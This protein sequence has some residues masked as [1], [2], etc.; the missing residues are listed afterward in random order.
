M[1]NEFSKIYFMT[2]YQ[3]TLK[4]SEASTQR[5]RIVIYRFFIG[6]KS[7]LM[8]ARYLRYDLRIADKEFVTFLSLWECCPEILKL[9]A[10]WNFRCYFRLHSR[11][12]SSSI[13]LSSLF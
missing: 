11:T 13:S 1:C 12:V 2:E 3:S 4:S 7:N 8:H 5:I 10:H 9:F 6:L